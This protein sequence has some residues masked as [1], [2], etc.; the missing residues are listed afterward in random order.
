MASEEDMDNIL[1]NEFESPSP[2]KFPSPP[3]GRPCIVK[4]SVKIRKNK[5]TYKR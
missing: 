3:K 4:E 1:I 2:L 5:T